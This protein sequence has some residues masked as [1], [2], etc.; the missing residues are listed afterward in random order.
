MAKVFVVTRVH[1]EYN[2]EWNYVGEGG[3]DGTPAKAF[4]DEA[5]ARDFVKQK[6]IESLEDLGQDLFTYVESFRD[7]VNRGVNFAD[8]IK[9][10]GGKVNED[11]D[12]DG[13]RYTLPSKMTDE[14]WGKIYDAL[15][16]RWWNVIPMET[17]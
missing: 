2:D 13:D 9:E 8:V 16:M 7:Y 12:W 17:E 1:W 6:N 3:E 4:R 14:K 5:K 15:S 10:I 11:A